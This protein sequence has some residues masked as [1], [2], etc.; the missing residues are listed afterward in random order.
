MSDQINKARLNGWITANQAYSLNAEHDRLASMISVR[1]D[2][3]FEIDTLEK[4]LTGLN[5]SIQDAMAATRATAGLG[6]TQ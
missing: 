4:G 1:S 6:P 3:K 2:S 5:L